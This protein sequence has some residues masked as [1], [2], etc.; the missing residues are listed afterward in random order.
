MTPFERLY[1]IATGP[2]DVM[3]MTRE[4]IG[5][6]ELAILIAKEAVKGTTSEKLSPAKCAKALGM[7]PGR[8]AQKDRERDDSNAGKIESVVVNEHCRHPTVRS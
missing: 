8:R 2:G 4:I 7:T 3:E 6:G 5:H 1:A